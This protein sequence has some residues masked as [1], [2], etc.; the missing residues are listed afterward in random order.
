LPLPSGEE[1]QYVQAEDTLKNKRTKKTRPRC[2][3]ING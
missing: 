1:A 2:C 3:K